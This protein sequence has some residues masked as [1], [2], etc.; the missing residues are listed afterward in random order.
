MVCVVTLKSH[1]FVLLGLKTS[2]T[3][4]MCSQFHNPA[5]VVVPDSCFDLDKFDKSVTLNKKC[6]FLLPG[7]VSRLLVIIVNSEITPQKCGLV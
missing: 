6:Q 4:D 7:S 5:F 3:T 1:L 2:T